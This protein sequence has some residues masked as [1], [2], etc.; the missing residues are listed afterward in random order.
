MQGGGLDEFRGDFERLA[1][2]EGAEGDF[3]AGFRESQQGG[4]LAFVDEHL[5][6]DFPQDVEFAQAGGV[7]RAVGIDRADDKA[8]AGR[9][10]RQVG[11]DGGV[12]FG[13]F[14]PSHAAGP[15]QRR[16]WR[17]CGGAGVT[18][19]WRGY[20]NRRFIRHGG[21]RGQQ[22]NKYPFHDQNALTGISSNSSR[23]SV[24]RMTMPV[25]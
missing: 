15:A 8:D 18:G 23:G 20:R 9:Q 14:E 12:R 21:E 11:G 1:A 17:C 4:H 7:G 6:A 3:I 25:S 24:M 19:R 2:A 22:E 16:Q 13:D 5:V 10:G